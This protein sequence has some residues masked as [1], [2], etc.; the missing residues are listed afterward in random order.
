MDI[1][2]GLIGQYELPANSWMVWMELYNSDERIV[3]I[4]FEVIESHFWKYPVLRIIIIWTFNQLGNFGHLQMTELTFLGR[5]L[6]HYPCELQFSESLLTSPNG[7][8]RILITNCW[9]LKYFIN[10]F[11]T[12]VCFRY[13]LLLSRFASL[14]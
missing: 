8:H 1:W 3:S 5:P 4:R 9:L 7:L 6:L 14:Q 13:G 10:I 2:L 12:E 11:A